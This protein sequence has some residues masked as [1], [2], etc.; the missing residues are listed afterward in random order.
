MKMAI[1]RA[2]DMDIETLLA[3]PMEEA[4]KLVE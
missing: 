4:E 2:D 3:I 1:R